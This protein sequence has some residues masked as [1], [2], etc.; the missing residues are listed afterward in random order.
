MEML[1]DFIYSFMFFATEERNTMWAQGPISLCEKK[2]QF[3]TLF[4]TFIYSISTY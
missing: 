2:T 1:L 3:I 4:L